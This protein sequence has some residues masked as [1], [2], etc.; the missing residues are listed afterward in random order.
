MTRLSVHRIL[1]ISIAFI[2]CACLLVCPGVAEEEKTLS[3][4]NNGEVLSS[5]AELSGAY[6]YKLYLNVTGTETIQGGWST[7]PQADEPQRW[8]DEIMAYYETDDNGSYGFVLPES[9]ETP[10]DVYYARLDENSDIIKVAFIY[11]HSHLAPEI[12]TAIENEQTPAPNEPYTLKWTPVEGA[13]GYLICWETPQS[14]VSFATGYTEFDVSNFW[15]PLEEM[16][17]QP[18][19]YS[20]WVAPLVGGKLG[21]QCEPMTFSV[22]G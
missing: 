2:L 16:T 19:E 11:D 5:G 14:P 17:A 10:L 1:R 22:E 21:A 9:D 15:V 18:G 6:Y 13:D 12:T 20:V 7:D 3:L 8:A 4:M